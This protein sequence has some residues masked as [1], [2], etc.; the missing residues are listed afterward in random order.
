V[1]WFQHVNGAAHTRASRRAWRCCYARNAAA[2]YWH[3]ARQNRAAGGGAAYHA[4]NDR[5]DRQYNDI[6]DGGAKT[7]RAIACERA[8]RKQQTSKRVTA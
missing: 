2:A 8:M 4:Q 3:A 1:T 7:R 6:N 5:S